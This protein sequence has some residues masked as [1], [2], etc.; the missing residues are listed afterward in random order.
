MSIVVFLDKR[1][2]LLLNKS[3]DFYP[4]D[5]RPNTGIAF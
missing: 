4:V 2:K 3:M 1:D 5:L